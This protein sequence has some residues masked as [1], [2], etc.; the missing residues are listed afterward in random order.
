MADGLKTDVH[1]F[2]RQ[3]LNHQPLTFAYIV[4]QI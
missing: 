2:A 4:M 1:F 3:F